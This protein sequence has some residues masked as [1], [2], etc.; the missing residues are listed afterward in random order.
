MYSSEK[1]D[2]D[3]V[4]PTVAMIPT[5]ESC[6]SGIFIFY[7]PTEE[8]AQSRSPP[9]D[10]VAT[11]MECYIRV[12]ERLGYITAPIMRMTHTHIHTHIRRNL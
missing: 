9:R 1:N 11:F 10:D 7:I 2:I 4:H 3:I 8:T 12:K 6:N 5:E